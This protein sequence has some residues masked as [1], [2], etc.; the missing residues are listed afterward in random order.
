M[1]KKR[2]PKSLAIKPRSLP[3]PSLSSAASSSNVT[4]QPPQNVN[5]LLHHLRHAQAPASARID[6]V[7]A[8]GPGEK[9]P[10][11]LIGGETALAGQGVPTQEQEAQRPQTAQERVAARQ[12]A[13]GPPGPKAPKSWSQPSAARTGGGEGAAHVVEPHAFTPGPGK[14]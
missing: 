5:A 9:V 2:T 10:M 7:S 8:L 14:G 13:R 6:A 3:H 1:P 12:R 11:A 4:P